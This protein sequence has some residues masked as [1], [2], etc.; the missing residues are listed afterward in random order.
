MWTLHE[1]VLLQ[2]FYFI[3]TA[4]QGDLCLKPVFRTSLFQLYG[5]TEMFKSPTLLYLCEPAEDA[6]LLILSFS[7]KNSSANQSVQM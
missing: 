4:T 1:W 5:F 3:T 2:T 7:E 6:V